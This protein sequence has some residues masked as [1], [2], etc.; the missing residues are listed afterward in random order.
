MLPF[1]PCPKSSHSVLDKALPASETVS[2]VK[3][4]VEE[5]GESVLTRTE[6]IDTGR[7]G[8]PVY[9]SYCGETAREIMPTA[10][11]MGK[12]PTPDQAEASALMELVERYSLFRFWHDESRYEHLTWSEA[13]R[14]FGDHLIPVEEM[15]R[16]VGEDLPL[17]RAEE[18]LDLIRWRFCNAWHIG[19][20]RDFVLP[21]DWFK[22]L[23]EFNGSSAGNTMEEA[24]LQGGCELI[25]RHVSALAD[26]N[27]PELPTLDPESFDDPALLDLWRSFTEQGIRI[28][29]KDFSMD[30]GVPTVGALAHDPGTFPGLSEI[31][32]TAG[33]ATSPD[34]AAIR[35]LTE[36]AQLA[37]DFHTGSCYDPSGL[38]KPRSLEECQWLRRGESIALQE[39]PDI[40]DTDIGREA[41]RLADRL[42]Q[43][44]YSLYS[45]DTT[46]PGLGIPATYS[47]APGLL[48]RERASEAS[49]GLFVGRILAEEHPA[50]S[51]ARGLDRLEDIYPGAHFL[52]FFHGLVSLRQEDPGE[53]LEWFRSAEPLQPTEDSK[54]LAAFYSGYSL[55][56]CGEWEASLPHLSR[57][58]EYSPANHTFRNQRGIAFFR[59]G[60][61]QEAA[62]EF[63]AALDI[64]AGSAVD[65]ANLG[66]CYKH[67]GKPGAAADFLRTSL[68]MDSTLDFARDQLRELGEL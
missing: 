14:R 40:S 48:F 11:Q 44:G 18:V 3:R 64:D 6:R 22:K 24:V 66:L 55:G 65:M 5:C 7:L 54:A 12:G 67:M 26:K 43:R 29:L 13:R 50:E 38:D 17:E 2:R 27:R 41:L 46:H 59:T 4:T 37:G 39:L 32:L 53:A 49:L 35:A 19:E 25:E 47:I 28:L 8:I 45:V 63:S 10:K 42:R 16:S 31:V 21:M 68:E 57:A 36:V 61:Y 30:M 56:L 58:A 62:R 51:A 15:L 52:P 23:N 60:R 34:K 9:I 1:K 20:Q 33:T